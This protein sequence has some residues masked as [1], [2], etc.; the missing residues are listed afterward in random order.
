[1]MSSVLSSWWELPL[2]EPFSTFSVGF[3]PPWDEFWFSLESW[4]DVGKADAESDPKDDGDEVTGLDFW[5][6]NALK[7]LIFH[8]DLDMKNWRNQSFKSRI[9]ALEAVASR[10]DSL[11]IDLVNYFKRE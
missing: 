2:E 4:E 8:F 10:R 11:F 3:S 7:L 9:F 5:I 6:R 1:M